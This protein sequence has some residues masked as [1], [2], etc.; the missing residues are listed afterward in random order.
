VRFI[1]WS[2]TAIVALVLVIFAVSNRE[3]VE[4]SF[5]PLP[6][7]VQAPLYLVVLVTLAVGFLIGE[8]AAWIGGAKRRGETRSLRGRIK[9]IERDLGTGAS[10]TTLTPQ[11][12]SKLPAGQ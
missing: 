10:T 12:I 3:F 7:T 6:A 8:F 4:L 1:Y 11:T 5:E 9:R 2:I